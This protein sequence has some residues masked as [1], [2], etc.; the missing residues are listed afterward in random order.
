MCA[1]V[2][3][4]CFADDATVIY[5]MCQPFL[6]HHSPV[7]LNAV[8]CVSIHIIIKCIVMHNARGSEN[9]N[10]I[11]AHVALEAIL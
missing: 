3:A 7:V 1:L 8:R 11:L 2:V 6:L 4:F 9:N 5:Q 10:D